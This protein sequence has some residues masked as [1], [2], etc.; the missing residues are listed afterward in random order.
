MTFDVWGTNSQRL[1]CSMLIRCDKAF[2]SIE[3]THGE[4]L[5]EAEFSTD[6][7]RVLVAALQACIAE[8]D[9]QA[10]KVR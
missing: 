6:A 9:R 7:L 5:T 3:D 10:G 1:T 8:V 2:L 4:P